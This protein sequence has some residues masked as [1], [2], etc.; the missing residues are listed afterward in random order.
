MFFNCLILYSL[1]FNIFFTSINIKVNLLKL[2]LD[3]IKDKILLIFTDKE[4]QSCKETHLEINFD[5]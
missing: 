5:N 3:K 2:V 4:G 1:F